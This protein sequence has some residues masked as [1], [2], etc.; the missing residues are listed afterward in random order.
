M[1]RALVVLPFCI[2]LLACLLF[3][4]YCENVEAKNVKVD[5][6]GKVYTIMYEQ[7]EVKFSDLD[8]VKIMFH[9]NHV[10]HSG[11]AIIRH[12]IKMTS[13]DV[14]KI[15][16]VVKHVDITYD[17]PLKYQDSYKIIGGI[18]AYGNTSLTLTVVG[19]SSMS[20]N[21]GSGNW[22][23]KNILRSRACAPLDEQDNGEETSTSGDFQSEQ[24]EVD[25]GKGPNKKTSKSHLHVEKLLAQYKED[26]ADAVIKLCK[27]NMKE[28]ASQKKCINYFTAT[29]TLVRVNKDGIKESI[30]EKCK[31]AF[32]PIEVEKLKE[33]ISVFC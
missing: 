27:N 32:P 17:K 33:L 9:S 12:L 22:G 21:E 1:K 16:Y 24:S 18:T 19:T 25:T 11:N 3:L 13:T 8:P 31:K 30:Q 20:R 23:I 29:Y 10:K 28:I 26:N 15:N 6:D 14:N 2:K 5:L 7:K 4:A